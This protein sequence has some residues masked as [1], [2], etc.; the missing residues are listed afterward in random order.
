MYIGYGI[1]AILGIVGALFFALIV[2]GGLLWMLSEGEQTKI[3]KAQKMITYAV[4]GLGIVLGAYTITS[5]IT[6]QIVTKVL[7]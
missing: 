7:Q 5:F 1:Q 4:A 2:Y 3:T 6:T